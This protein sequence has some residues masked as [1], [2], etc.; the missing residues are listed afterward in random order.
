MVSPLLSSFSTS[1]LALCLF[2]ALSPALTGGSPPENLR[3][4]SDDSIAGQAQANAATI[5]YF[6]DYLDGGGWSVQLVLSNVAPDAPAGV[7]VKVF[8]PDAQPVLDLFDSENA[9]EIPSLS[10]RVLKS[11]GSGAIR[12]GWIQVETESATVSGLLTYRHAQSGIEVGVEPV[13]LGTEFALFVEESTRVGAGFAVFKPD[14]ASRL[15]LRIRDEEGE[16]PLERWI[17]P[18]GRFPPGGGHACGMVRS[19]RSRY[20][21]PGELSR[22]PV[23]AKPGRYPLCSARA[24]VW[25][26]DPFTLGGADDAGLGRRRPRRWTSRPAGGDEVVHEGGALPHHR[27]RSGPTARPDGM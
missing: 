10:S 27:D 16:R 1:F 2:F 23:P 12:R 9:L 4:P 19:G 22:H 13:R 20:G 6:P 7:R 14:V 18:L 26:E 5:L 21:F 8:D 17:R 15:E 24:A 25:E 11:A 3:R